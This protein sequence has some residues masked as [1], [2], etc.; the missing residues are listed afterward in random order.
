MKVPDR[1]PRQRA[2]AVAFGLATHAL[3]LAGVGLM[4][5]TLW[6]GAPPDLLGLR[7][8]RAGVLD[9]A[10]LLQFPLLH[11]FFLGRR[12]GRVLARLVPLGLG[13]DLATT[14]FAALAS[15][16]LATTF[17]LWAPSQRLLWRAPGPFTA[18]WG[19]AYAASWLFLGKAMLD[20]GLA[21]Q[22]G[23]KGWTTVVRGRKLAY[24]SF[25]DRGLFRACRQPVYLAFAAV[26]WTG[27]VW[28][29]DHLV[30]ALAWTAYCVLGPRLKERRY[31]AR[32]GEA[33][34]RYRERVPYFWPWRR[35]AA[36]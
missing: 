27:P 35:R 24:G 2:F 29:V 3:F 14:S 16:Q 9:G 1:S 31:L 26:L 8:W 5:W 30:L 17:G 32:H 4:G 10:L 33:F 34:A 7:G 23:Y 15:L 36:A 11:S 22:L 25:P 21:I 19:V 6:G 12:G 20:A 13:H 18:V 28:T